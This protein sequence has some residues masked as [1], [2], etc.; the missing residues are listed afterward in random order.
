MALR[1]H[2]RPAC[3][4]L[5]P[6]AART[7]GSQG[8]GTL[9]RRPLWEPRAGP[10]FAIGDGSEFSLILFRFSKECVCGCHHRSE[11][12]HTRGTATATAPTAG[13]ASQLP[14]GRGPQAPE[15]NRG[16]AGQLHP[17]E[18]RVRVRAPHTAPRGLPWRRPLPLTIA[19]Q[20][21][22]DPATGRTPTRL[23][24]AGGTGLPG[25]APDRLR[26][27]LPALA[28]VS[29]PQQLGEGDNGH[30]QARLSKGPGC[31]RHRGRAPHRPG[32]VGS[33][34]ATCP[35]PPPSHWVPA[36]KGPHE[37]PA[38][39]L[40]WGATARHG[41]PPPRHTLPPGTA[42]PS[43]SL[44]PCP[45]APLPASEES[46]PT[47]SPIPPPG[48]PWGSPSHPDGKTPS[49]RPPTLPAHAG[50]DTRGPEC[51]AGASPQDR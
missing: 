23:P 43:G 44:R 10:Q 11:H 30:A 2:R 19:Y 13:T 31:P 49:L 17:R 6:R 7:Q 20:V 3:P 14:P 15:P 41:L 4:H 37:W 25:V 47:P 24:P 9:P 50:R 46:T 40:R 48:P 12:G 27:P 36:A 1:G 34:A 32:P 35:W 22:I 45:P 26:L 18:Q 16:Q 5:R 33:L 51:S 21:A 28:S 39:P 42:P 29:P 38:L 8:N